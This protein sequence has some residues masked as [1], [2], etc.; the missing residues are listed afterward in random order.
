MERLHYTA[1]EVRL[2]VSDSPLCG[3]CGED[4]R[5]FR[6]ISTPHGD[7]PIIAASRLCAHTPVADPPFHDGKAP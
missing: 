6:A 5:I 1:D 4:D 2:A 7:P 3:I